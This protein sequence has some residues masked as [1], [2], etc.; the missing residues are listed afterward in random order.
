[1]TD[2]IRGFLYALLGADTW[3]E[4]GSI[5]AGNPEQRKAAHAFLAAP[6]SDCLLALK[7]LVAAVFCPNEP[8]S[9]TLTEA[10]QMAAE[11][12]QFSGEKP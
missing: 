7:A 6:E 12:L 9:P 10:A 1:M 8:N 4:A 2:D 5:W 3:I 11:V